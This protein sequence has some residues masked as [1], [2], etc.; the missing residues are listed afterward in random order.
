MT[1]HLA[2]PDAIASLILQPKAVE[3]VEMAAKLTALKARQDW[4]ALVE[5]V[6]ITPGSL[7][8]AMAPEEIARLFD[9]A[10]NRITPEGLILNVPFRMRRRGVELKLHLGDAPPAIDQTLVRKIAK[11]RSWLAM[12][13]DGKTFAEIARAEGTST[14]R[15]QQVI[16][17][18]MLAPEVLDEIATGRQPAGLTTDYLIKTGFPA[19][20]SDQRRLFA[21]L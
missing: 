18:A 12:I 5:R 1:K 2:R 16:E 4:L 14:R 3:L 6:D 8:L 10:S 21:A 9:C 17:L 19:L 7:T 20:W 13:I 15:I 11:A